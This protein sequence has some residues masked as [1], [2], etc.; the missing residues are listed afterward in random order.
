MIDRLLRATIVASVLLVVFALPVTAPAQDASVKC[1]DTVGNASAKYLLALL[2]ASKPCFAAKA[3]AEFNTTYNCRTD[4]ADDFPSSTDA[5]LMAAVDDAN[6]TLGQAF[7]KACTDPVGAGFKYPCDTSTPTDYA[8]LADFRTCIEV[9]GH[10]VTA[11]YIESL[12]Y[13][14]GEAIPDAAARMCQAAIMTAT[15]KFAAAVMKVRRKCGKKILV[16]KPCDG[17]KV[18]SKVAAARA[19]STK[20]VNKGCPTANGLD[21]EVSKLSFGGACAGGVG[22]WHNRDA[23]RDCILT[24]VQE[25]AWGVQDIAYDPPPPP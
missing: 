24:Q 20:V 3:A 5:T 9:R 11:G 4:L 18:A 7:V 19:A 25:Q 1:R 17:E 14:S 10:G 12:V 2:K 16:G 23:L 8:A 22:S 21:S 13:G 15:E 6:A